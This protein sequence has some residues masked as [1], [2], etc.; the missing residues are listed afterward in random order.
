MEQRAYINL[1]DLMLCNF[2][3]QSMS[4]IKKRKYRPVQVA[5]EH[6]ERFIF[7][8]RID[9]KQIRRQRRERML[10][11]LGVLYTYL[12]NS[13]YGQVSPSLRTIA[14][15]IDPTLVPVQDQDDAFMKKTK[16]RA[17]HKVVMSV[18]RAIH[19]LEALK[20]LTIHEY[21]VDEDHYLSHKHP[22]FFYELTPLTTFFP[23][24]V[25]KIRTKKTKVARKKVNFPNAPYEPSM[26]QRSFADM[27]KALSVYKRGTEQRTTYIKVRV[28]IFE[29]LYKRKKKKLIPRKKP[30]NAEEALKIKE[31]IED[32][33]K[34]FWG[35]NKRE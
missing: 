4:E 14:Y 17:L 7:T 5:L 35:C 20:I 8:A 16:E 24:Y 23:D 30:K 25:K 1:Y 29:S 12:Y 22:C 13:D 26:K 33:K 27:Q 11:V 19:T 15:K 9:G 2:N 32:I 31:R 18:Q 28:S 6:M 34:R 3:A 21:Y 10:D